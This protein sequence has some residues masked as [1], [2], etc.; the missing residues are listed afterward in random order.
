[1][2]TLGH[3]GFLED[4]LLEMTASDEGLYFLTDDIYL[5]DKYGFTFDGYGY[6]LFADKGIGI[7]AFS[8]GTGCHYKDGTYSV[9]TINVNN[10]NV[11]CMLPDR[12]TFQK[13]GIHDRYDDGW[14]IVNLD[15]WY[16]NVEEI[17]QRRRPIDGFVFDVEPIV[18]IKKKGEP[19]DEEKWER[20]SET[21]TDE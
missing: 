14:A 8:M 7:R 12:E 16:Q 13:L 2:R 15:D 18:Y 10:N 11:V 19:I 21:G 5:I 17:W 1:M 3:F 9:I 20:I 4:K 6:C